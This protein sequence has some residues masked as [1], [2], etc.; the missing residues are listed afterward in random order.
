M[1]TQSPPKLRVAII[2]AGPAGLAA[3]IEFAK[4]SFVEARIYEQARELREM[5]AGTSLHHNTWRMLDA[6][7]VYENFDERDLF[8]P[9]DGHLVQ[10]R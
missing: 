10:H 6:L 2:G 4:L 5:G 7:G 9:A 1:P 8:R 3:A